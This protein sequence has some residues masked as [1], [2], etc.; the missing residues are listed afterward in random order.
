M[1]NDSDG[2]EG[3]HDCRQPSARNSINVDLLSDASLQLDIDVYDRIGWNIVYGGKRRPISVSDAL[4]RA[5][6]DLEVVRTSRDVADEVR[7]GF[8]AAV[9]AEALDPGSLMERYSTLA[10][11][12]AEIDEAELDG[13]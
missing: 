8:N 9:R 1:Q 3:A 5:H 7:A 12:D 6:G 13:R 2:A 11:F 10:A 4:V